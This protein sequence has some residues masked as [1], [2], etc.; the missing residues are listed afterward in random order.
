M[1]VSS[2]SSVVGIL[3]AEDAEHRQNHFAFGGTALSLPFTN[4]SNQ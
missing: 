3:A 4:L 1:R 2:V